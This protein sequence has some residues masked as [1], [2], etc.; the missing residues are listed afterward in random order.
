MHRQAVGPAD[1]CMVQAGLVKGLTL[2]WEGWEHNEAR[3]LVHLCNLH[4]LIQ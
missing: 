4:H 1:P 2:D 3:E